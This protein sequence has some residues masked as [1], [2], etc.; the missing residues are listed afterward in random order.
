M[1]IQDLLKQQAQQRPDEKA[2]WFANQWFTYRQLYDRA[3]AVSAFLAANQFQPGQRVALVMDNSD[4]YAVFY[5][6]VLMAGGVVAGLNPA[7]SAEDLK[8]LVEDCQAKT[9]V[10]DK[11]Y[12]NLLVKAGINRASLDVVI[13]ETDAPVLGGKTEARWEEVFAFDADRAEARRI[14]QDLAEIVYTSGSTGK[15][16][17]VMLSHLNIVT[18]MRS[19]ATYMELTSSDRA[20]VILPFYYIFGKSVL[21]SHFLVG[22]SVVIDN[23]FIFPNKVIE[24]MAETEV[25]N[26][27]GVPSTYSILLSRSNIRDV[28]LP[29]LRMVTQAGGSMAVA[30]QKEVARV[31]APAKLWVMYGATEAAPRLSYLHP[32]YFGEKSGSI[33]QPVDNVELRIMDDAGKFLPP[34]EKGEIVA[35][36]SNIMLGYWNDP[37]ATRQVVQNG[38]YH[39]GDLGYQDADGFTFVV[40]RK[41]DIVKVKGFRVSTKEVEEKM[42]ELSEVDDVAVV[43]VEDAILGEA[44]K[45]FVVLKKNIGEG[46]ASEMDKKEL[47]KHLRSVLPDYKVPSEV[48]FRESLPKNSYGKILKNELKG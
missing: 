22:A 47:L 41:N 13:K 15:P 25:T 43:G 31:F 19:I 21:L 17:G 11:K 23:R 38:Y 24:T 6:G 27:S 4:S 10:V 29:A 39:T 7:F 33:G 30:L 28:R 44:L 20:M 42:F 46:A 8:V 16:K 12:L 40:G 36:G 26:F 2:L 18:N 14:D 1:L 5:F 45:A 34:G 37:E 48:E 35:R 32:D 9:L 3:R